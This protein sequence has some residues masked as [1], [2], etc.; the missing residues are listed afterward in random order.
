MKRRN[1]VLWIHMYLDQ[2]RLPTPTPR[3]FTYKLPMQSIILYII[4]L[5]YI[6][7][8]VFVE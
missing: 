8:K 7:S 5:Y 4:S 1:V 6:D 2:I 3:I